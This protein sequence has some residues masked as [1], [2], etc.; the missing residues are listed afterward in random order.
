MPL[1]NNLR[2]EEITSTD[3]VPLTYE[4]RYRVWARE[5]HLSAP[6]KD[7][8]LIYDEHDSHAR[9]WAIFSQGVDMVAAARL[10]IHERQDDVPD[11][12]GYSYHGFH[13]PTP[14][15]SINRLVV[16]RS[17]RKLGIA[18]HLDLLRIEVAR[19]S[20]AACLMVAAGGNR[21]KSLCDLGFSRTESVYN[22]VYVENYQLPLL[23]LYF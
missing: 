10:C 18:N 4:L 22:S 8:G 1:P 12:S 23:V 21:M 6:V 9:H 13:L 11:G 14:I 20:G 3:H 7:K 15:A 2:L 17:Y 5:A 16:E 19:Q